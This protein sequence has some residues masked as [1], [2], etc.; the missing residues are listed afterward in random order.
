VEVVVT[1][2]LVV[3]DAG[4]EEV[5]VVT[6]GCAVD[7]ATTVVVVVVVAFVVVVAELHD[8]SRIAATN[9]K[10]KPNQINLRFTSIYLPFN[11]FVTI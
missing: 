5:T 10:D 2:A 4:A 11:F 8:A 9:I 1:T 3:L 7:V 6:V